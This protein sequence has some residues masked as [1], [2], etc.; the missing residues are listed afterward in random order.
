ME[1]PCREFYIM[2]IPI[3]LIAGKFGGKLDLVD[4][5]IFAFGGF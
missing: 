2:V 5:Q 1:T 3:Y 4:Q